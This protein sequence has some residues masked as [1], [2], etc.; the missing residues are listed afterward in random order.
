MVNGNQ[1]HFLIGGRISGALRDL[2]GGNV[3]NPVPAVYQT[4]LCAVL[5][6]YLGQGARRT[7][8][9]KQRGLSADQCGSESH[10]KPIAIFGEVHDRRLLRKQVGQGGYI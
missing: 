9:R 4:V 10:Q 8:R 6:S 5:S 3:S 7:A 2:I 1:R